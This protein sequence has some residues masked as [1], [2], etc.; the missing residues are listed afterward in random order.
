[1]NKGKTFSCSNSKIHIIN[2]KTFN[3]RWN[4][5]TVN[6]WTN[7]YFGKSSDKKTRVGEI[8]INKDQFR[9]APAVMEF[10]LCE[11]IIDV[12]REIYSS[13]S[14]S[15]HSQRKCIRPSEYK[16]SVWSFADLA[17]FIVFIRVSR[18]SEKTRESSK[19]KTK[20]IVYYQNQYILG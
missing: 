5:S 6:N 14:S 4:D 9:I 19:F 10:S 13:V 16:A 8:D 15:S 20:S 17:F 18:L 12:R 1:M 7:R 11:W 2:S 3:H